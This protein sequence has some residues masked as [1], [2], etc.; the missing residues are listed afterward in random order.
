ME[1][2]NIA[3]RRSDMYFFPY[4]KIEIDPKFNVRKDFGDI[5]GLAQD[6]AQNGLQQPLIFRN[7]DGHIILVDGHR[8]FKAIGYAIKELKAPIGD[9]KCIPENKGSNEE[10]RIVNMFGTGTNV[11]PLTPTEQASAIKRLID[12]GW[13]VKKISAQVGKKL[14][15][16]NQLLE[17]SGASTEIRQ[18]VQ[19]KRISKTAAVKLMKAS[20]KDCSR[21]L[22]KSVDK[23]I[24]V[25]DV[26]KAT[27][28]AAVLI[29]A[30]SIRA[31]IIQVDG[32]M[33][34]DPEHWGAV[35][36][37]LEYALGIKEIPDIA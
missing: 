16:V 36:E 26:E 29:T 35:K 5:Q 15:Y 14:A 7:D 19:K 32:L 18:A 28:G 25:S 30:G 23:K 1:I 31:K 22:G 12:L 27:T 9:I 13:D 3:T 4:N 6:I 2:K 33:E 20:P 34:K 17:L 37:G 21:L 11:K 24:K 8:R 10:T